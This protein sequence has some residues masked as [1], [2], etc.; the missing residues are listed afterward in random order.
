VAWLLSYGYHLIIIQEI[1]KIN[2]KDQKI[3]FIEIKLKNITKVKIKSFKKITR[4]GV[5]DG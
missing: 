5:P 1:R 3:A 4:H 2:G